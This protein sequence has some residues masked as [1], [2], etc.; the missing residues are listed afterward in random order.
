M[1]AN[2]IPRSVEVLI[3]KAAVDPEFRELL[4]A[5]RAAA[6]GEIGLPLEPAE[7]AILNAIPADQ[8]RAIIARTKVDQSAVPALLGKAAAVMLVALGISYPAEDS[9]GAGTRGIRPDPPRPPATAPAVATQPSSQPSTSPATEPSSQPVT[10]P[11][12]LPLT[13]GIRPDLIPAPTGIRPDTVPMTKGSRPDVIP[14]P[15]GIRPDTVPAPAP[16]PRPDTIQGKGGS[17]PDVPPEK[18]G[19]D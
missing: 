1:P 14:A 7:A 3:K 19:A 13:D 6:A 15:T 4:L 5:K 9:A 16:T 10:R 11:T 2:D 18:Q 12:T 8:L 17:R